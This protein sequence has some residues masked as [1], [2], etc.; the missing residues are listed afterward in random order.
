MGAL[1]WVYVLGEAERKPTEER[2]ITR[3]ERD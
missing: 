1:L 3:K 2:G